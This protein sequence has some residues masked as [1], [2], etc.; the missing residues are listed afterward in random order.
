M[1]MSWGVVG[2]VGEMIGDVVGVVVVVMINVVIVLFEVVEMMMMM[3]IMIYV[4]GIDVCYCENFDL[5]KKSIRFM[6]SWW[7]SDMI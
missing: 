7:W 6:L 5:M 1:V 4:V 2:M 3:M